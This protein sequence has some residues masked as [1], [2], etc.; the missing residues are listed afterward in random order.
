MAIVR[1]GLHP[2]NLSQAKHKYTGKVKPVGYPNTSAICGK[3]GCNYP[4]LVWLTEE[5]VL[6]FNNGNRIFDVHTQTV[7]IKTEDQL[8]PIV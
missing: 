2:V 6:E 8:L 7:Q 1:C 3:I 5:E 4:G